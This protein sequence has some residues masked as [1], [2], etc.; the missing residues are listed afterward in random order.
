MRRLVLALILILVGV[1]GVVV[2]NRNNTPSESAAP[3]GAGARGGPGGDAF[4]RP[5]M[6]VEVAPVRRDEVTEDM[7]V[8]G[9]LVGAATV[10]VVSRVSGRL[11]AIT[12]R[13]GDS[14][15]RGQTLAQVE[16]QEIREQVKQAEASHQVAE[17]TIR[18][19]EAD[20]TFAGTNLD[21]SRSLFQRDLLPQQ[22]LDDAEARYQAARAQLDLARAQFAQA[23]SRL[24]ELQINLANT[25]IRSPVDGFVGRR[26]M[27]PGAWVSS[28]T[29]VVSLVDIRSVRLEA[30]LVE[31]DLRRVSVGMP[32]RVE[33]DAF[34][35]ETFQGQVARV[36]PVLDPATR[37]AAMEIEVP[38]PG[39]R[40]KPGMY[41]RVQFTVERRADALVVPRNALVDLEGRRGV[42]VAENDTAHFRVVAIGLQDQQKVE[43]LEGI[44]P[45]EQVVTAGAAALRDGDRI[46]LAGA[47]PGSGGAGPRGAA[48]GEPPS[49]GTPQPAT[50]GSQRRQR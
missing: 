21:R 20:L 36:S 1:A 14:V 5:P 39:F 17:A 31:R 46:I 37:T 45:G 9:N 18:Q 25:A 43:V 50:E 29:P 47:R 24:E 7:M 49:A 33:V 4:A 2:Y 32:A 3:G 41:A 44:Q 6:T 34:P 42:F 15:S 38:N 40:L 30:S 19:R 26:Y 23:R 48:G 22:T 28:N 35:G 8:V 16:D 11:Q 13:I 10:E 12:V 27:D